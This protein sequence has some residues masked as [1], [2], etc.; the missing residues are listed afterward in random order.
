[1]GIFLLHIFYSMHC[2]QRHIYRLIMVLVKLSLKFFYR[3]LDRVFETTAKLA[4]L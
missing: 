4:T 3:L 1:M 2:A